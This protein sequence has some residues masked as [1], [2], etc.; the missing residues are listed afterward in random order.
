MS[1]FVFHPWV[2][3][4]WKTTY[5]Q[6]SLLP[7]LHIDNLRMF[8]C[9]LDPVNAIRSSVHDVQSDM[10]RKGAFTFLV[11]L[12]DRFNNSIRL[13]EKENMKHARISV[14]YSSQDKPQSMRF[15][16]C[17]TILRSSVAGDAYLLSCAG[18]EKERIFF[19]PS[20]NNVPL[21]GQ[22]RYEAITTLCPGKRSCKG[23]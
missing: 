1:I 20:I 6:R 23:N 22:D 15:L 5:L 10:T 17:S 18:A 16:E 13:I 8:L 19:Y 11:V 2:A 3:T 12:R 21:G 4:V 7:Y 9:R 14:Q